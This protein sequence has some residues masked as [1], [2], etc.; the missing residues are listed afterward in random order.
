MLTPEER[1]DKDLTAVFYSR[2][3]KLTG[4]RPRLV[5]KYNKI[6][7]TLSLNPIGNQYLHTTFLISGKLDPAQLGMSIN[8]TI[9]DPDGMTM[10]K[11]AKTDAE[12][13]FSVEFEA[14][15]TGIWSV[16]AESEGNDFF[17]GATSDVMHFNVIE[18]ERSL[19]DL[20][21]EYWWALL[22]V[23]AVIILLLI[24]F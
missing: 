15:K 6:R 18:K 4:Y 5:I 24:P 3:V 23:A 20:M 21:C 11:V 1:G 2:E 14:D 10:S 7:P 9:T 16:T 22:T 19:L 12:G 8:L 13:L 17:E